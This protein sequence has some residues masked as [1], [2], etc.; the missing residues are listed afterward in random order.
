MQPLIDAAGASKH[1]N[2]TM[3]MRAQHLNVLVYICRIISYHIVSY[4]TNDMTQRR[5]HSQLYCTYPI[6]SCGLC[7]A[8]TCF[9]KLNFLTNDLLHISQLNLLMP[10]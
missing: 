8:R 3:V 9:C 6:I 7:F 1:R 4:L 2:A 5:F 10:S